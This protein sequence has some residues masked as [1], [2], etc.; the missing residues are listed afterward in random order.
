MVGQ[1]LFVKIDEAFAARLGEE[2]IAHGRVAIERAVDRFE[3]SGFDT[4]QLSLGGGATAH[5][6]IDLARRH[7]GAGL[8]NEQIGRVALHRAVVDRAIVQRRRIDDGEAL[9][10][11]DQRDE[12]DAQ[13]R[14]RRHGRRAVDD[15][16]RVGAVG[17]V[18]GND[19]IAVCADVQAGDIGRACLARIQRAV[20]D[21]DVQL[22]VAVADRAGD[23]GTASDGQAVRPRSEGYC[24]RH[25]AIA[26]ICDVGT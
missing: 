24:P 14:T 25:H 6:D 17:R 22:A 10:P 12:V 23:D 2:G 26:E 11:V 8:D 15:E 18:D 13:S 5:V 21:I 9:W 4:D 1:K 3:C 16:A 7:V 19:Q 20:G